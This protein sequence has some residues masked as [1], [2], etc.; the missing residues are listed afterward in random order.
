LL[1]PNSS[2][3]NLGGVKVIRTNIAELTNGDIQA[4][5]SLS[6]LLDR[7]T[8]GSSKVFL[9]PIANNITPEEALSGL[10]RLFESRETQINAALGKIE[11]SNRDKFGSRS[12]ARPWSSR[13]EKLISSFG[14]GETYGDI[15]VPS[16][17]QPG[18]LRPLTINE[19]AKY[20]KNSTNSCL[21]FMRKKSSV[22]DIVLK[23]ILKYYGKYPCVLFTRTQEGGKDRIIWGYPIADTLVEMAY[24]RPLLK[25][26]IIQPW[27]AALRSPESLDEAINKLM[28]NNKARGRYL[29]SGDVSG[30]DDDAKYFMQEI[31]FSAVKSLYQPQYSGKIDEIFNR[32]NT[33]PLVTPDGIYT[34]QH[35]IPSGSTFTN[36]IGSIIQYSIY[37][38]SN[39]VTMDD[40]Q[41]Q[42]DD[43]VG[44]TANPDAVFQS[45]A[46]AG[47]KINEAKSDV[48]DVY[49]TYLQF[50]F[51]PDYRTTN[52]LIGGVYSIYR[53]L[54]RI[55]HLESF[56]DIS[57]E[58][59]SGK[60]YFAIRTISIMENCKHH[61]L[62]KEFVTY[63]HKLD[64]YNLDFSDL[65]LRQFVELKRRQEGKD[66]KFTNYTYGDDISGIRNFHSF[67][68]LE[69]L[70]VK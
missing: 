66:I 11:M 30:F 33:I 25:H 4:E 50:L 2:L 24:Y 46:N 42:G 51:H 44:S 62:F 43:S 23:D 61:P 57:K 53:A 22:K 20:L 35:G 58:D 36:E 12:E 34:G 14:R 18:R 37:S 9:S 48:S 52:G 55:F 6:R 54:N 47:F 26:Q 19:A 31:A 15:L 67:K 3:S 1:S 65:G 5:N 28:S 32:F 60:D 69:E 41:I 39:T 64:K 56:D 21:P 45:F 40:I 8:V 13:R 59:I 10:D 38:H 27:R 7:T 49:C 68:L 63:I 70:N 16:L 29:I 17:G